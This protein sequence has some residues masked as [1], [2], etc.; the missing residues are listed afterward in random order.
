MSIHTKDHSFGEQQVKPIQFDGCVGWLHEGHTGYG[1]VL[2]EP[3]GHEALWTHKLLRA[4]AES[5]ARAGIWVL[6]F[7]YPCAGDSAGDDI[8]EDR[9]LKILA[10]IRRAINVLHAQADIAD[11]TLLGVRAGAMF[12]MLAAAPEEGGV[13]PN[14]DALVALSP[15]VRGRAYIRELL[16]VQKG[17]LET[18][19]PPVQRAS[20][21]ESCMNVLGHRYPPDLVE[22]VKAVNLCDVASTTSSLARSV[23]LLDTD[24]GD[25]PMLSAVLQSRGIDVVTEPFREWPT[26]MLE[27][28]QSRLPFDAIRSLTQWIIGRSQT[29]LP[30]ARYRP[31][32]VAQCSPADAPIT[33]A[34]EGVAE[35]LVRI[36]PD[37]LVGTLCSPAEAVLLRPAAPALLIASTAAN[38]RIA[39]GRFAVCLAREMARHGIVTLRMDVSGVGDSGQQAIDDQSSIPYSDQTVLDVVAAANW[40]TAQGHRGV[41]ALGICS[42]AYASL[43]AATKTASLVGTIPINLPRFIW[44]AGMTLAEASSQRVNSSRGYLL[45]A[46]NWRKWGRLLR[47]R[48]DLRPIARTLVR[49]IIARFRLPMIQI[50]ER[51]GW[52]PGIDT[53]RGVIRE[54]A[55]R[56]VRTLLIYGEFD[57]G[58]NELHR[59]FGPAHLA[60]KGSCDVSV[61]TVPQLDHALFGIS[62]RNTVID[63]CVQALTGW[64]DQKA[65]IARL[66]CGKDAGPRL[67]MSSAK[68]EVCN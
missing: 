7:N 5:L 38:P 14:V 35:Q 28:T 33:I 26:T 13:V 48:R 16:L 23:L 4:L 41:V 56:G 34:A 55:R 64:S 19:P 46:R 25:S 58:I 12:A 29:P 59:H 27:S 65:E 10:S 22:K 11:L 43:H 53:E 63:F 8:E 44:P 50:T 54:V 42:G 51:L 21:D 18:A 40:L 67:E 15:V 68:N 17:W 2:C 39:D 52:R 20:S 61:Q 47:E 57:P 24:Y 36:G 1:V 32:S 30:N 49:G 66:S 6:R 62:G 9:F 3:L 60:F 37:R 31:D 45:S